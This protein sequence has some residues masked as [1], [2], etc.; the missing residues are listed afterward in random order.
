MKNMTL[1]AIEEEY[2]A[3]YGDIPEDEDEILRYLESNMTLDMKKI[4]E[5][6]RRIDD[7][8]WNELNFILPVIPKPSPR[9]RY[10]FKTEHFY[11]IGAAQNKK[12]IKK[13]INRN[14]IIYTRTDMY[15]ETYQP[16]PLSQMTKN[17]IYL[18]EKKKICPIQN[19]D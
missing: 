1:Q 13:H 12:L 6:E 7:I 17:E 11:V 3:K 18:A 9:P 2:D 16:T 19:P 5:E 10:S 14:K 15:I 4:E 8:P